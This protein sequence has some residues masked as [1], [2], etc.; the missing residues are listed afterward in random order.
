M[1]LVDSDSDKP[2]TLYPKALKGKDIKKHEILIKH[3]RPSESPTTTPISGL[4]Q[5]SEMVN[6]FEIEVKSLDRKI[7]ALEEILKMYD[8]NDAEY[9]KYKDKKRDLLVYKFDLLESYSP[10]SSLLTPQ[11]K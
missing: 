5:E 2:F 8:P 3:E 4:T 9:K 11:K 1:D 7:V 10:E 6:P